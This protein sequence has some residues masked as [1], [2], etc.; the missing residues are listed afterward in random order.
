MKYNRV[1]ISLFYRDKLSLCCYY[2]CKGLHGIRGI[3]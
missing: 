2:T 1:I 3:I